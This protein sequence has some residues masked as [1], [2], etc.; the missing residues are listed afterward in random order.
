M[1]G[2]TVQVGQHFTRPLEDDTK[3][4]K[5]DLVLS[6]DSSGDLILATES[7]IPYGI[8]FQSSHDKLHW[9]IGEEKILKGSEI[10]Y[11]IAIFRSG[12]ADIPLAGDHVAI[13]IGDMVIVGNSAGEVDKGDTAVAAQ[14]NRKVGWAEEAVGA[15]ASGVPAQPTLRVAL[16][17]RGGSP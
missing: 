9:R 17:I 15:S 11:E 4:A 6:I 3:I 16:E 1:A 8:A 14:V 7:T 10:P 5:D 13:G 12:W 2:R